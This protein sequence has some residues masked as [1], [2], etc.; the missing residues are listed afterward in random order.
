M[1]RIATSVAIAFVL[2]L[3]GCTAD[4]PPASTDTA[5]EA[6]EIARLESEW[7][8][9]FGAGDLDGITDLLTEDTV[10]IMPGTPPIVGID[11]VR[12]A[13]RAM[14]ESDDQVSWR[15]LHA[16]VAPSGD[17]AYDYGTATTVL[18]DGTVIEGYYMVVWVKEDGRWKVAAD[19]FN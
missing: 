8:A 3:A 19:M 13:T 6:S 17:M 11:D 9:M 15:S 10:L 12:E 1:T 18:A 4:A 2:A 16:L 7:S 5:A 14:L